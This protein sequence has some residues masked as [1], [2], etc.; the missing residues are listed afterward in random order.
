P[1]SETAEADLEQFIEKREA[2]LPLLQASWQNYS[3]AQPGPNYLVFN[4]LASIGPKER[5]EFLSSLILDP[6]PDSLEIDPTLVA[7]APRGSLIALPPRY[8]TLIPEF[9]KQSADAAPIV[10]M[11]LLRQQLLKGMDELMLPRLEDEELYPFI[12][13]A[14]ILADSAAE[15]GQTN[16]VADKLRKLAE[17]P[18][19]AANC[20]LALVLQADAI[21][22][23]T[24]SDELVALFDD[25]LEQIKEQISESDGS[26]YAS[27]QGINPAVTTMIL[28]AHQSG[29]PRKAVLEDWDVLKEASNST[30]YNINLSSW[31][32]EMRRLFPLN[33]F[34]EKM[35]L[36]GFTVTDT[37]TYMASSDSN[38]PLFHVEGDVNRIWAEEGRANLIV[39]FPVVGEFKISYEATNQFD[40]LAVDGGKTPEFAVDSKLGYPVVGLDLSYGDVTFQLDPKYIQPGDNGDWLMDG[41]ELSISVRN[42]SS[43][44]FLVDRYRPTE[45]TTES[46]SVTPKGLSAGLDGTTYVELEGDFSAYPWIELE[47]G[48]SSETIWKNLRIEGEMSIPRYVDLINDRLIGFSL[49]GPA[50]LP[51]IKVPEE[52]LA[53]VGATDEEGGEM[54]AYQSMIYETEMNSGSINQGK[55]SVN[56]GLLQLKPSEDSPT[57]VAESDDGLPPEARH[58]TIL[59]YGRPLLEGEKLQ[60]EFRVEE[61]SEKDAE[62]FAYLQVANVVITLSK[63]GITAGGQ[64]GGRGGAPGQNI[65]IELT[66]GTMRDGWNQFEIARRE[67]RVYVMLNEEPL[68]DFEILQPLTYGF[69]GDVR[70]G[71]DFKTLRLTGPWPDTVPE[72][73]KTQP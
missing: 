10:E 6:L 47:T 11:D 63:S 71:V 17:E 53:G 8:T 57:D 55:W 34:S 49:Y 13:M 64:K 51:E 36:E 65:E 32:S 44:E 29:I 70:Y 5:V 20:L 18:G 43:P 61:S 37:A 28:R 59:T 15:C 26:P 60:G 33:G 69:G 40:K 62:P 4:Y 23:Q 56:E 9:M 52:L 22:N 41:G 54:D 42:E 3:L 35:P 68:I 58:Q 73:W 67:G 38:R 12:D 46:M 45:W 16:V 27:R 72:A 24:E 14:V 31:V 2:L 48:Y 21:K 50:E 39:P 30:G 19:D 7:S 1:S 25:A 66:D